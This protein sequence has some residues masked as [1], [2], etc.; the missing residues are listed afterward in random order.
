[1]KRET[2]TLIMG[3]AIVAM[4]I[5]AVAMLPAAPA[6]AAPAAAPTPV[7]AAPRGMET[8]TK[9]NFWDAAALTADT[10][11]T[12]YDVS[13]FEKADIYYSIDIDAS[14]VNTTTVYMQHG[15]DPSALVNGVAVVSA[16]VAD[17]AEMAQLQVFGGFLCLKADVTNS[18]AVTIT[19]NALVK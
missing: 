7:S 4:I 14:N 12:C 19:A 9:I 8:S 15:N 10:T 1:M 16:V 13:A 17:A 2:W 5:V 11:S 6:D 18:D 3:V